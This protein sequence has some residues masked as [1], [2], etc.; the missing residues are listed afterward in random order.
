MEDLVI[1]VEKG[2]KLGSMILIKVLYEVM[3]SI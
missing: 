1:K 3:G 2:N